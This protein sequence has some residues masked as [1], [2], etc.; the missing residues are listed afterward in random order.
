MAYMER[1]LNLCGIFTQCTR[2]RRSWRCFLPL[3]FYHILVFLF[4]SVNS[5]RAIYW[6]TEPAVSGSDLF[7]RMT[8]ALLHG[9]APLL[10][11]LLA[12]A[13]RKVPKFL[14]NIDS[15][16]EDVSVDLKRLGNILRQPPAKISKW[17]VI[18]SIIIIILEWAWYI[19]FGN[20]LMTEKD[21]YTFT[22]PLPKGHPYTMW[23]L[24]ILLVFS[25]FI[26]GT[27]QCSM[28][29]LCVISFI[30]CRNL[31]LLNL[32]LIDLRQQ[33]SARG[34]DCEYI[35]Y[36]GRE[37][38]NFERLLEGLGIADSMFTPII[39]FVLASVLL[40]ACLLIYN[41]LFDTTQAH[42]VNMALDLAFLKGS[43][44]M[45]VV[46]LV[47]CLVLHSAVRNYPFVSNLQS[48]H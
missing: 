30:L 20:L 10:Y 35:E 8:I 1:L 22:Y 12:L 46:I 4:L 39:S 5:V 32:R 43:V 14:E 38:L 34:M 41:F 36:F 19:L 15:I 18:M 31:R 17:M 23:Y 21:L 29:F 25:F 37:R 11:L 26:F 7:R 40:T 16:Q 24:N 2:Q 44:A 28:T 33:L 48:I 42:P 9:A 3:N 45:V 6:L 47:N 27:W 13:F